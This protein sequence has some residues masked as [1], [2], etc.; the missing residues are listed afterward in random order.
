MCAKGWWQTYHH[1]HLT[2][3]NIIYLSTN[4]P[5]KLSELCS[6][7]FITL[8]KLVQEDLNCWT[9]LPI[10]L[11]GRTAT[12]KMSILPIY[13]YIIIIIFF[14]NDSQVHHGFKS[15][16]LAITKFRKYKVPRMKLSTLQKLKS[17]E[18]QI[19]N[20][21]TCQVNWQLSLVN[22]KTLQN[23]SANPNLTPLDRNWIGYKECGQILL[24]P[25]PNMVS[26]IQPQMYPQCVFDWWS[27][28]RSI[29][30]IEQLN[31]VMFY[32]TFYQMVSEVQWFA[33]QHGPFQVDGTHRSTSFW[34]SEL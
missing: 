23:G 21:I 29:E 8:F 25:P 7:N 20:T 12:I 32:I 18:H 10:S 4:I 13:V 24:R 33:L 16:N 14:L 15:L 2:R 34:S 27:K 17:L 22:W 3:R 6:L 19:S 11:P 9:N 31:T 30:S 26:V 28:Y 1:F 5:S